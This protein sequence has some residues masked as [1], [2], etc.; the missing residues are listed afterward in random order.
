MSQLWVLSLRHTG[1]L[2]KIQELF[3]S[4]QISLDEEKYNEQPI[5]HCFAGTPHLHIVRYLVKKG[6]NV[7]QKNK[8]G[9]TPLHIATIYSQFDVADFLVKKGKETFY[10]HF[11]FP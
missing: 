7:N 9:Q 5:L 8:F 1:N 11:L 6:A 4:G 10:Y 2:Q 3:E